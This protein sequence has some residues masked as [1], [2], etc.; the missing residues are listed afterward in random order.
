M[1]SFSGLVYLVISS[2]STLWTNPDYYN[3]SVQ[4]SGLH[5]IALAI[6]YG[7]GS[8]ITAR[9]NDWTYKRLKRTRGNGKGVPEVSLVT[10]GL[11]I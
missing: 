4:M 8:Q 9:F 7:V 3:M 2:F 5:F 11:N 10:G 1:S 6:G